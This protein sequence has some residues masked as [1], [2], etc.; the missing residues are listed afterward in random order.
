MEAFTGS[1]GYVIIPC[2]PYGTYNVVET[3]QENWINTT[4]IERE[5]IID[6][7]TITEERFGNTQCGYLNISK[8]YDYNANGIWDEGEEGISG[9]L[10]TITG[11]VNIQLITQGYNGSVLTPC[12]PYDSYHITE[13]L[14]NGW[15]NTTSTER[16]VIINSLLTEERFGNKQVPATTTSATTTSTTTTTTTTTT[17]EPTT[18]TSTTTTTIPCIDENPPTVEVMPYDDYIQYIQSYP[19]LFDS[20]QGDLRLCINATDDCGIAS[21]EFGYKLDCDPWVYWV[22][23]DYNNGSIYCYNI[24][25]S[26][27]IRLIDD[28]IEWGYKVTDTSGKVTLRYNVD[29]NHPI[30]VKDDDIEPSEFSAWSYKTIVPFNHSISVNATIT[31]ASGVDSAILYYDYNNDGVID[32]STLPEV[33]DNRYYYQIPAPCDSND[34]EYCEQQGRANVFMRFRI[35]AV[36][37]DNDRSNDSSTI[38]VISIPIFI[39]PPEEVPDI[40]EGLYITAYSPLDERVSVLEGRAIRFF[41]Y[42]NYPNET[43]YEWKLDGKVVSTAPNQYEYKPDHSASGLH[44]LKVDIY[45]G[46]EVAS[47][48]WKIEVIN[49]ICDYEMTTTTVATTKSSGGLGIFNKKTT[50]TDTFTTTKHVTTTLSLPT[51]VTTISETP[52]SSMTG[53]YLLVSAYSVLL[54]LIAVLLFTLILLL[55]VITSRKRK[56]KEEKN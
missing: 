25:R 9:W 31:D 52:S 49:K 19:T 56:V 1:G 28:I 6:I 32:G 39:D 13:D 17:T 7:P 48:S 38:Q 21:A 55:L 29:P 46:S 12:L 24:T 18:T 20:Y 44:D 35:V 54:L 14:Y 45:R 34:K 23:H 30:N 47:H 33:I 51:T 3:L 27:W 50:T 22:N 43:R 41:A 10:F 53:R 26:D 2:I 8:F 5:T 42:N 15:I 40:I 36:D 16:D 11:P 37:G 4:S